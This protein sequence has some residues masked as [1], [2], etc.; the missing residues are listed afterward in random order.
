M[1][2]LELVLIWFAL[3]PVVALA[4]GALIR[5][6]RGPVPAAPP[7]RRIGLVRSAAPQPAPPVRGGPSEGRVRAAE[8]DGRQYSP[9][10]A[11]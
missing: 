7:G 1:L 10:A 4:F 9:P 11:A 6:G 2:V 5:A 3:S 8:L